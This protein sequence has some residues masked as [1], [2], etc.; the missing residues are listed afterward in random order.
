MDWKDYYQL[1]T[2]ARPHGVKGD[3]IIYLDVDEPGSYKNLKSVFFKEGDVL[4]ER[5]ITAIK[6]NDKLATVHFAGVDD[7]N[8]AELILKKEIFL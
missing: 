1:G 5:T 4:N 8:A 2:I 7:R 3:V 6:V